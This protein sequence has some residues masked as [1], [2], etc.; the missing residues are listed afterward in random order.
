MTG[1]SFPSKS[2]LR[3]AKVKPCTVPW[4]DDGAYEDVDWVWNQF[5]PSQEQDAWLPPT[6]LE[7][8]EGILGAS[9]P[10]EPIRRF[11][12]EMFNPRRP[13]CNGALFELSTVKIQD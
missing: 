7:S 5:A 1:P 9:L 6:P 3:Q 11:G 12:V 2:T 10:S 8:S 13:I 4:V